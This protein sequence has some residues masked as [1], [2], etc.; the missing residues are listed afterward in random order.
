[1]K[2]AV[3]GAGPAGLSAAYQLC[4]KGIDVEIFESSDAIAGM[5][6]TISL[7]GQLVDLGPHRFFSSDP[8]VNKI[9]L[10]AIDGQYQMVNRLTRIYYKKTFFNY[11][12]K[13]F[14][15]LRGLG[16]I[17]AVHCV[18]SYVQAKILPIKNDSTFESWV[19]NR[20]GKRLFE[21]F[22]KSYSEKLWGISCRELDADF[23]A[24]RIKNFS[25]FEAI[26][27]AILPQKNFKH[28]TLVDE[29]AYPNK[30]A[31]QV[32][33]KMAQ[34]ILEFG[35][36]LNLKTSVLAMQNANSK[37]LIFSS[38]CATYGV[39]D[40]V[41]IDETTIQ[42]PINPYGN[43][44]LMVE[45]I[46]FDLANQGKLSQITLRY[47]NAAGAD[48][49]CEIGSKHNPETRLIP[50]A[51]NSAK[52]GAELEIFGTDFP[53]KD[54]TAI[55][56]YVHVEDL[57]RAHILAM[58]LLLSKNINSDFINLGSG[59]GSSVLEIINNLKKLGLTVN[60]R[61]MPRR[62]SDPASLVADI[63][64]AKKV[65]NWE[66]HYNIAEILQSAILWNERQ[67]NLKKH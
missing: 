34:K 27:S 60:S 23:A 62:V 38:S 17:E 33:D 56:D 21:I 39:C 31:G 67:L 63:S 40:G 53:T 58:K 24:Q 6:K 64:K 13:A 20:F 36:K 55:R 57:G 48:K 44:K 32:Y 30:G 19:T 11:P 1:M 4:K 51:I 12:L 37:N 28:K 3:I 46:L 59:I 10:E 65:L 50:L 29:F 5:V 47:F 61:N 7:W 15:A 35:G 43:S 2:I 41:K 14:N 16:V 49:D 18:M 22:F 52:D 26:K 8:R 54:K 66:P 42:K 9:W 45:K 25:L